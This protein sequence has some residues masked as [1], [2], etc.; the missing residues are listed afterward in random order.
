MMIMA[1]MMMMKDDDAQSGELM[2]NKTTKK[3]RKVMSVLPME[4]VKKRSHSLRDMDNQQWSEMIE[5]H[6]FQNK[7]L[8]IYHNEARLISHFNSL[9]A[10][11]TVHFD[12][13]IPMQTLLGYGNIKDV[14]MTVPLMCVLEKPVISQER[15]DDYFLTVCVQFVSMLFQSNIICIFVYVYVYVHLKWEIL[16]SFGDNIR[17]MKVEV[18]SS[19]KK[20]KTRINELEGSKFDTEDKEE[21]HQKWITVSDPSQVKKFVKE[22]PESCLTTIL[23]SHSPLHV[24][25]GVYYE[26]RIAIRCKYPI[27]HQVLS[28]QHLI[29]VPL[30]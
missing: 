18:R 27:E 24:Q 15:A 3:K 7:E 1:M 14:V 13:S 19:E 9:N 12:E 29:Y 2:K 4:R 25:K 22:K 26:F 17:D 5:K 10:H 16:S 8:E 30:G 20:R 21:E 28:N 6:L 23:C 11:I